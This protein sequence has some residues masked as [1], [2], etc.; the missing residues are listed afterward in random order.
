MGK[1]HISRMSAFARTMRN[2]IENRYERAPRP[3]CATDGDQ[4][5]LLGRSGALLGRSWALLG[6]SWGALG[7]LLGALGA[8]LGALGALLGRSWVALGALLG[9]LGRSWAPP[10]RSWLDFGAPEGRFWYLQGW[11]FV[12]PRRPGQRISTCCSD[13]HTETNRQQRTDRD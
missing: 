8:L 6:R 4:G 2:S 13:R 1:T 10:G 11:I 12:F 3:S 9:A 7:S 5:Q